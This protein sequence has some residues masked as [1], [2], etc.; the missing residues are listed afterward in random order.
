MLHNAMSFFDVTFVIGMHQQIY[1]KI[2]Y[3]QKKYTFVHYLLPYPLD[4]YFKY[5]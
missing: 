2:Y 3:R 1:R 4:D 5:A